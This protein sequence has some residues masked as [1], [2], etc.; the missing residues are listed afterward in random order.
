MRKL[1]AHA[2]MVVAVVGCGLSSGCQGRSRDREGA[3]ALVKAIQEGDEKRA[4]ELASYCWVPLL[5]SEDRLHF[6]NETYLPIHVAAQ[7]GRAAV[8]EEMIRKGGDVDARDSS[9]YTPA[10]FTLK[11]DPDR[12]QAERLACLRLLARKGADLNARSVI[13]RNA[14]LHWAAKSGDVVFAREL[15]KL[16]ADVR[17]RNGNDSTPLHLACQAHKPA[18]AP[19]PVEIAEILIKAGADVQAKNDAGQTP[20][21]IARKEGRE[22][23]VA[24]LREAAKKAPKAPAEKP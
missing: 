4:K 21:D 13:S 19:E 17:V 11:E 1:L 7:Q 20:E 2:V 15:V 8:L 16:G 18:K 9:G 14:A 10:V 12:R 5:E 3:L 22:R 23:M 24:L 6:G